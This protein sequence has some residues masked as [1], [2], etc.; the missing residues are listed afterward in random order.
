ML[1]GVLG[2]GQLTHGL[3]VDELDQEM[4]WEVGLELLEM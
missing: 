2:E 1:V 3:I 4:A